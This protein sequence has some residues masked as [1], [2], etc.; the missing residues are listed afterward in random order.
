[1]RQECWN[2]TC[3]S[4]IDLGGPSHLSRI[5]DECAAASTHDAR[6]STSSLHLAQRA[7]QGSPTDLKH[8]GQFA[9]RGKSITRAETMLVHEGTDLYSEFGCSA[10]THR[11]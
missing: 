5:G 2:G 6:N 7:T 8:D 4:S 10:S 11:A 3:E 1:M 9:F